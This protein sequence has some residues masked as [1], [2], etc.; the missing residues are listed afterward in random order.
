MDERAL[1]KRISINPQVC[2]GRPC[3]KGHRIPV[4][5]ILDFLASGVSPQQ[6]CS[7]WYPDLTLQDI[8]ACIA[9]AN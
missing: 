6:L 8:Y 5:L 2:G 1:L 4:E 9:F 7:K 3:I